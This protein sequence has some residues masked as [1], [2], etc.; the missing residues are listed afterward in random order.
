M[1]PKSAKLRVARPTDNLSKVTEM[2][3]LGLSPKLLGT[4]KNHNGFDGSI[5][6]NETHSYHLE[7]THHKG[8]TVGRT[9]M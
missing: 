7:F 3:V 5:I 8:S 9:P 6:V 2:C 4:F 1:I